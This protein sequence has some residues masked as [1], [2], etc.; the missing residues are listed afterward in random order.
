MRIDPLRLERWL[1]E[2]AADADVVL[3][4]SHVRP[5]STHRFDT[6]P[7]ALEPVTAAETAAFRATI[8]DHHGRDAE[9]TLFTSGTRAANFLA[10]SAL[11]DEHAVVVT[12][13]DGSLPDLAGAVAEVTRVRLD[14]PACRLDPDSIASAIRPETDIVAIANP[15]D[16]T[17]RCHDETELQEIYDTCADN[18]SHVLCDERARLLAPDSPAPVASLGRHGISTG[19]VSTAFG[20]PGVGFGWLC[21][22][23]AVIAAS[24]NWRTHVGSPP[25]TLDR[26]VAEQAF[27]ERSDLLS[28]NRSH[29]A[30]NRER[31]ERFLEAQ[32]L[33][34][35]EPDF[36]A[37][38]LVEVPDGFADGRSF[39]RSLVTEESVALVPG[40]AFEC[41]EWV[42]VGF[43]GPRDELET[44]LS[45]LSAFFERHR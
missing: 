29:V 10:V 45:R 26:H 28:A 40:S 15:N 4:G 32:G 1:A 36:G 24:K 44:G 34:W 3:A 33:N 6:D 31:L 30:T 35:S 38:A 2:V 22:S 16:P 14:A 20:L 43:G 18:G 19:G 23:S 25:S 5:V 8:G 37:T 42:Q 9:E 17:G 39:C 12:P 13:T 41:P 27:D 21:G 7:G 11:T